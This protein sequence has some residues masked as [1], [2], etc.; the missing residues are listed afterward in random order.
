MIRLSLLLLSLTFAAVTVRAQQSVGSIVGHIRL[1]NPDQAESLHVRAEEVTTEATI[2][3]TE[4]DSAGD[5]ALRNLPF[6]TYD[7]YLVSNVG[8]AFERRVVVHSAVAMHVQ[9][10]SVPDFQKNEITVTD[11]HMEPTQPVVHTLFTGPTILAL[12]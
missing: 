3:V 9:F 4:I 7:L 2:E 6:A 5:F 12:P 8:A 1:S 11:T 10:D